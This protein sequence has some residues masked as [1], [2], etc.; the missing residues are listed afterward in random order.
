MHRTDLRSLLERR[1]RDGRNRWRSFQA[2]HARA[3]VA[4]LGVPTR[5]FSL[6][7]V[8]RVLADVIIVNACYLAALIL[9]LLLEPDLMTRPG[10]HLGGVLRIY[11]SQFLLLTLLAVASN[12][13]HGI[14]GRGRL[15]SGRFKAVV[16]AQAVGI[17]YLTFGFFQY[18]GLARE[19][20][21]PTPRLAM[22]FG[23][24]FTLLAMLAARGAASVWSIVVN[25]EKP[26]RPET[27]RKG[28]I[29]RVLVIGG[30]GYIG[31]ILCRDLLARGYSVRVLDALLYGQES[32]D[33]LA[34]HP[35]F[36]LMR[37]D[38]RDI[39]AVVAAMLD[40]DAV[41][42]LG[43]LVGDPACALN[44]RLTLEINLAATRMLAEVAWGYGIKRFVYASSCS[45]YGAAA[46][47]EIVD[48]SSPLNP[49]SLYARAKVGCE[50]A[51]AELGDDFNPVIL[52]LST[53]FG[54][55]YRPRFDLVVNLLTAQAVS[56]SD[57]TVFGGTQYRPF[58]HVTDVARAILRC[59]EAPLARVKGQTFNV[60][61]DAQNYTLRDVGKLISGLVPEAERVRYDPGED[62]RNYRVSFAKIHREL[63]FECQ[64]GLEDGIRDLAHALR[65]GAIGDYTSARFSNH[66]TLSDP[67]GQPRL[68]GRGEGDW[69]LEMREASASS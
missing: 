16:L 17:T 4:V 20:L 19:A 36:E 9:R 2:E 50:R 39:A 63:G 57:I 64:I 61:S 60:G 35:R 43:E 47:D 1:I 53:V 52:R 12:A 29:R 56:G 24:G 37:G 21:T 27:N 41:V 48:E 66:K 55:S 22:L 7:V 59:L 26:L 68:R 15:Y 62:R 51:L 14:Y 30:A 32:I 18:V 58:V 33:G 42:H 11:L 67:T 13:A 49:V 54:L 28:P 25:R 10:H 46:E 34:G 40:V 38:S 3:R 69:M 23:W 65:S 44:E 45:V 6:E 5:L 31:S 8:S